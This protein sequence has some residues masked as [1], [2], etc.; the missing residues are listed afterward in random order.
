MKDNKKLNTGLGYVA[1]IG[2]YVIA[3]L[4]GL[5]VAGRKVR[6]DIM[7]PENIDKP[8]N[9]LKSYKKHF[10]KHVKSH[11][12]NK[13]SARAIAWYMKDIKKYDPY[14]EINN[15][16]I[17][18][19]VEKIK[20]A[21]FIKVIYFEESEH[22]RRMPQYCKIGDYTINF[23]SDGTEWCGGMRGNGYINI[24]NY[25]TRQT[26]LLATISPR[27]SDYLGKM[28]MQKAK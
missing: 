21:D 10:V 22:Q 16:N 8:V 26:K 9:F 15:K 5:F 4:G 2:D 6:D 18:D 3:A 19:I 27:L 17:D 1:W 13:L 11:N 14:V 12:D 7:A 20:N 25:Q 23:A 24:V 28:V